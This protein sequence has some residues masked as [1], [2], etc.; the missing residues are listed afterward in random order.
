M[1]LPISRAGKT[2][3]FSRSRPVLRLWQ[4]FGTEAFAEQ[5]LAMLCCIGAQAQRSPVVGVPVRRQGEG[6]GADGARRLRRL[7]EASRVGE[8]A[9]A[10]GA[11]KDE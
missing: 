7:D 4:L 9:G 2:R 5:R 3:E 8:R 6:R 10:A 11:Q 1:L